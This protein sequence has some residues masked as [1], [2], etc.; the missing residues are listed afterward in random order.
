[1]T[2]K[3]KTDRESAHADAQSN[4]QEGQGS[5]ENAPV[6]PEVLPV[7]E[8]AGGGDPAPVETPDHRL[9]R[10]QADFDN[11]RK[12][13]LREKH[14]L[15]QRANEDLMLELLPV[16]DHMELALDSA[17]KHDAA[18]GLIEGFRLVF[19]Q[20]NSTLGKFGLT[21]FETQ[22]SV[23]N[24]ESQEAIAH[25]PDPAVPENHVVQ[26]TRRGYRLGGRLLRAAQVVVSSGTVS[27][28]ES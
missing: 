15:Y 7:P 24:P 20:L 16:L 22:G 3:H 25:L 2:A 4:P 18:S 5:V 26:Q 10:L 11:F 21:A 17:A 9:L 27:P 23:F 8:P 12:R 1:M 19:E 14:E 6:E 13:V 28:A